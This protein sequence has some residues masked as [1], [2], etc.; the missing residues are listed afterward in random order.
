MYYIIV[1]SLAKANI[2]NEHWKKYCGRKNHHE[3]S[4]ES[5]RM[6][7]KKAS[8]RLIVVWQTFSREVVIALLRDR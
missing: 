2:N 1:V 6:E 7:D 4:S 8:E 3:S 5:V